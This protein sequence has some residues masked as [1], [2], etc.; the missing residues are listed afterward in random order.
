[1][2]PM[3]ISRAINLGKK[4]EIEIRHVKADG[5]IKKDGVF[6]VKDFHEK[7]LHLSDLYDEDDMSCC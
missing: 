3:S 7:L 5:T 6:G 4:C 2:E 1:M